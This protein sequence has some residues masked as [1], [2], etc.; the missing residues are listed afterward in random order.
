MDA[1]FSL[2]AGSIP[3]AIL[4]RYEGGGRSFLAEQEGV[5]QRG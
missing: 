4:G 3:V 5:W 1:L 2:V